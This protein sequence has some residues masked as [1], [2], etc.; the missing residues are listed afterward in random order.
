[1]INRLIKTEQDYEKALT[2]IEGLM[3]A[4][5]GTPELDELELLTALVEMYEDR[6]YPINPPDPVE[7]IRF[8]MDRR[9]GQALLAA[10]G[11]KS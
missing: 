1:M 3:D 7:A 8:R 9:D 6:H 2:R 5:A 10:E 11:P 4:E